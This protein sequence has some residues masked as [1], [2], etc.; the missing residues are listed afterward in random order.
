MFRISC[1]TLFARNSLEKQKK[2]HWVD[3]KI[4]PAN[5]HNN[6]YNEDTCFVLRRPCRLLNRLE[7]RRA[8]CSN[9]GKWKWETTKYRLLQY[10]Y[11]TS[12]QVATGKWWTS[13]V[14]ILCGYRKWFRSY[15]WW[16]T[17]RLATVAFYRR[18]CR[19][20]LDDGR[21][22]VNSRK[23][24]ATAIQEII[25]QTNTFLSFPKRQFARFCANKI[26]ATK[27]ASNA[28]PDRISL[29]SDGVSII[30][31]II[32]YRAIRQACL[33]S[34]SSTTMNLF[35]TCEHLNMFKDNKL[36]VYRDFSYYLRSIWWTAD[37]LLFF[38]F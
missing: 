13:S 22:L 10:E 5:Y 28:P 6:Y 15:R 12:P 17:S 30:I 33:P 36:S 21:A 23:H 37:K 38:F 16:Y 2:H 19:G 11:C 24:P 1:L 20:R 32:L 26:I 27:G 29:I 4:I 31:I 8:S 34:F 35:K 7:K 3:D 14:A 25:V 9:G 18:P